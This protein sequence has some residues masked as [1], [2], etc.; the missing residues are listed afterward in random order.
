MFSFRHTTPPS[1]TPLRQRLKNSTAS[2]SGRWPRHHCGPCR[3]HMSGARKSVR[4][5]D[6]D[7]DAVVEALV[8]YPLLHAHAQEALH[9]R[10]CARGP[11]SVRREAWTGVGGAHQAQPFAQSQHRWAL[12]PESP[13]R[14]S[15]VRARAAPRAIVPRGP[16]TG[17]A[18]RAALARRGQCRRRSPPRSPLES[19]IRSSGALLQ[20][21]VG[22]TCARTLRER[23]KSADPFTSAAA[24]RRRHA[25]NESAKALA[26]Q[27]VR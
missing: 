2:S 6:L 3:E 10:P 20:R 26:Y 12:A 22:A 23:M 7:P 17:T 25:L 21:R 11:A 8:R 27:W 16:R 4:R 5:E 1:L 15:K 13:A 24:A 9:L 19:A 18:D 14:V